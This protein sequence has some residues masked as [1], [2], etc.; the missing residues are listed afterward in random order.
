MNRA[1]LAGLVGGVV[2]WLV[3]F[4]L[5]GVIMAPTYMKYTEVFRQEAV[6]PLWFLFIEIL[7][8]LPAAVL[9]SRTRGSWSPGIAGGVVF[10]FWL[11]LIGSFAQFFTPLTI[12]GF[13]YYMAWCWWGM[14]LLTT[15]VLGAVFG[16][17]VRAPATA[18]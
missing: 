17:M 4:L 5:H 9:F 13:P 14:N 3:S 16:A 1:I 18:A 12:A 7:I 11:G 6:N 8:A 2:M 10:G 15:M